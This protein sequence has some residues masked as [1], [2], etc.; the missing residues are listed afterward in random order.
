[1]VSAKS[2]WLQACVSICLCFDETGVCACEPVCVSTTVNRCNL[3]VYF[4]SSFILS[5]SCLLYLLACLHSFI[6]I[7]RIPAIS[8]AWNLARIMS[9][10]P[11]V[12]LCV[13]VTVCT[14]SFMF[15]H[16]I[17]TMKVKIK[18]KWAMC[19]LYRIFTHSVYTHTH[20]HS[21]THTLTCITRV[22]RLSI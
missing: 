18:K 1:M 16:V 20:A 12:C 10:C 17:E 3:S 11:C 4:R 14:Q 9:M 6:V 22:I 19:V 7:V 8:I 13:H 15:P 2:P 21:P 5:P